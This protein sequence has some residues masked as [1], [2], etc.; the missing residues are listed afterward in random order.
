MASMVD[1]PS[2]GRTGGVYIPP[3][4]LALMKAGQQNSSEKEEESQR[5]SW[6]LLRKNLNGLINKVNVMNI[7]FC[8]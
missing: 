8:A 1:K 3:F 7:K 6:E 2:G 4:K 5:L